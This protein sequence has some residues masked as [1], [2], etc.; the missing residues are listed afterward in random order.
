MADFKKVLERARSGYAGRKD[1]PPYALFAWVDRAR[2]TAYLEL[3]N[4]E[5]DRDGPAVAAARKR[6]KAAVEQKQ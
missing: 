3:V 4:A 6:L 1:Y 5:L 2:W